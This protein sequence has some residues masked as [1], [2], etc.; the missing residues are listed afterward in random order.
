MSAERLFAVKEQM[1][2]AEAR[3]LLLDGMPPATV[4]AEVGFYDQAH[5]HRHFRNHL[6]TTPGRFQRQAAAGR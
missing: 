1:E 6:A 5:L 3:R 2:M 4:A